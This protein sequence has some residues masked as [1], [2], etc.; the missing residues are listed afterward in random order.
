MI[1]QT[2]KVFPW[3]PPKT[4]NQAKWMEAI[5]KTSS[6]IILLIPGES[7]TTIPFQLEKLK[8]KKSY[9]ENCSPSQL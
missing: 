3:Q 7:I 2:N 5:W 4:E 8:K 1:L 6:Q 9:S